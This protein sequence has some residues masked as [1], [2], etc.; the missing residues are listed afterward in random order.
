MPSVSVIVC[1]HNEERTIGALLGDVLGQKLPEGLVLREVLVVTDGCTDGTVAAVRAAA[2]GD[3]RIRLLELPAPRRGKSRA[4]NGG[5]STLADD[6]VV[7][8]DADVRLAD[9]GVMARLTG[10]IGVGAALAS[11]NDIPEPAPVRTIGHAASVGRH[12]IKQALK[13]SVVPRPNVYTCVGRALAMHRSFYRDLEIPDSPGEDNFRYFTAVRRRVPYAY[14]PDAVV[15]FQPARSVSDYIRQHARFWHGVA[16]F[17]GMFGGDAAYGS[18][19]THLGTVARLA[20]S[21]P[22][23]MAAWSLAATAGQAVYWWQRYVARTP[24]TGAWEPITS[25]K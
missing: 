17:R 3:S 13:E 7:M 12:L 11:G 1:A 15:F 23:I 20:V 25:T 10:A 18:I 14:V 22:L 2:A 8:F 5:V 9:G 21:H 6:I 4:F 16:A 19:G 24:Q